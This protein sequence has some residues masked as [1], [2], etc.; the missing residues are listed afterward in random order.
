MN[1]ITRTYARGLAASRETDRAVR[2][3]SRLAAHDDPE[4]RSFDLRLAAMGRM[5]QGDG[6]GAARL[7]VGE[8]PISR[9]LA[10]YCVSKVMSEPTGR[11]AFDSCAFAAFGLSSRDPGA[12]RYLMEIFYASLFVP[13]AVQFAQRL[14]EVAPGDSES[15]AILR[16]LR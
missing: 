15:A 5:A 12:L 13:Q 1:A 8:P 6:P 16:E 10:L 14:Q 2:I 9:D 4:L 7:L 11:A 3:L